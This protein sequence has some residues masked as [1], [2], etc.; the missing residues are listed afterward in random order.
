MRDIIDYCHSRKKQLLIGC[1]AIAHLT[2]WR[3]PAAIQE[4]KASW[5]F[6]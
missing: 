6:L 1:D 4:E 5:N 3:S 2:L